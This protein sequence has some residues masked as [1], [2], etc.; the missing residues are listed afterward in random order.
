LINF[1]GTIVAQD[2]NILT[3]N[4]AFFGDAVF[5]TVKIID[6]KILFRGSLF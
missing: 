3:Q 5:E 4:R 1:N 6:G 2:T